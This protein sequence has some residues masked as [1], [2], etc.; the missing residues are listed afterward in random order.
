MQAQMQQMSAQLEAEKAKSDLMQ[1]QSA[2]MQRMPAAIES[3]SQ[4]GDKK[5]MLVDTK[6][7]GKPPNFGSGDEKVLEKGFVMWQRKMINYVVEDIW[8]RSK[9]VVI[10][11]DVRQ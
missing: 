4:R 11:I 9:G 1:K 10:F 8:N 6:G 2:D 5:E 3:L 7:I